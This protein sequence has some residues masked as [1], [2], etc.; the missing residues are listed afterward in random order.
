[1]DLS[2]FRKKI[3]DVQERKIVFSVLKRSIDYKDIN[4]WDVY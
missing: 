3:L 1:M 2:E 4:R